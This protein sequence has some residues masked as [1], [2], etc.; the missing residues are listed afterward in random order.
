M[1]AHAR[2]R[3]E[4]A[5]EATFRPRVESRIQVRPAARDTRG[6]P[7]SIGLSCRI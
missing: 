7:R 2:V 1:R 4:G 6:W 5:F 3:I